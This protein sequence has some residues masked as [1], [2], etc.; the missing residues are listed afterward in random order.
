MKWILRLLILLF[1]IGASF[2][3]ATADDVRRIHWHIINTPPLHITDD[4]G[5]SDVMVKYFSERMTDWDHIASVASIKRINAES[6][7]TKLE[8]CVTHLRK[9]SSR[10][11]TMYFSKPILLS[12]NHWLHF[13]KDSQ[14]KHMVTDN[15]ISLEEVL[16]ETNTRYVVRQGRS[17]G[18]AIDALLQKYQDKHLKVTDPA[19]VNLIKLLCS[20]R[21]DFFIEY[22]MIV[23]WLALQS[24]DENCF[25][26]VKLK[27]K[28]LDN[29]AYI[30][31]TKTDN[32]MQAITEINEIIESTKASPEFKAL[33]MSQGMG[34]DAHFKL[35]LEALYEDFINE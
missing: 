4:S 27:E 17:Y 16:A 18:G 22:P 29:H 14:L 7:S 12:P 8:M 24:P 20:N 15:Q 25:V 23:H 3:P 9:T 2:S 13:R 1:I 30:A 26:S 21:I 34:G 10:E 6:A 33:F 28:L 31:C 5:Y 19:P 32:G 11:K 35:E